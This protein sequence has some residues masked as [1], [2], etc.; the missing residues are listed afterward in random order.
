MEEV[1]VED[2][3]GRANWVVTPWSSGEERHTWD[4]SGLRTGVLPARACMSMLLL[5]IPMPPPSPPTHT[6]VPHAVPQ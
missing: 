4:L 3:R 1:A 5:C 6:L 2:A